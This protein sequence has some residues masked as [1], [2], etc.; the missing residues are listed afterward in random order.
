MTADEEQPEPS[1][2]AGGCVLIAL[3]GV[4][5][6]VVFAAS[7]E[8]GI[9]ATVGTAT[10]AVWWSVRRPSKIDNPSPPPPEALPENTK[11]QFSAV[12]DEDNPHRTHIV[13]H[14]KEVA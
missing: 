3:T 2:A 6:A 1:P 11:P 9:L 7:P 14:T 8:A 13:W 10:A 12:P 5:L 4:P